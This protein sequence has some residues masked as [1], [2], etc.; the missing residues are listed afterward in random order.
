MGTTPEVV[1]GRV[2]G[3]PESIGGASG[4]A[5]SAVVAARGTVSG[6]RGGPARRRGNP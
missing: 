4:L 3:A 5:D 2:E 6:E 1:G